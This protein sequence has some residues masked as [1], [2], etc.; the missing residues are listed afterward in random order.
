LIEGLPAAVVIGD[1]AYEA[2][3]LRQAIAAKGAIAVIPNNLSRAP[4]YPL[5]K[6]LYA[7]DGQTMGVEVRGR[8]SPR[9]FAADILGPPRTG[10]WT[11]WQ[12]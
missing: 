7:Q 4:K 3:H 2:D 11:R 9:N 5:D 1:T 6:H 12:S 8:Y 10:I